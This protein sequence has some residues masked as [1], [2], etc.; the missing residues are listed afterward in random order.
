MGTH[1]H[2]HLSNILFAY[3]P[4]PLPQTVN[5]H[6]YCLYFSIYILMTEWEGCLG[7]ISSLCLPSSFLPVII[8]PEAMTTLIHQ[9]SC[10]SC[11]W[12]PVQRQNFWVKGLP[13]FKAVEAFDHIAPEGGA[14]LVQYWDVMSSWPYPQ[15]SLPIF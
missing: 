3:L 8:N 15:W 4:C 12:T 6:L 10:L 14:P 13:V 1:T 7:F 5:V 9:I 2:T 11:A